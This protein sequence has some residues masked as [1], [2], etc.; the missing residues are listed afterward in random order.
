MGGQLNY[1]GLWL[2]D[3]YG[4]GHSMAKPLSTTYHNP[5]LSKQPEFKYTD[6]EVWKVSNIQEDIEEEEAKKEQRVGVSFV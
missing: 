2:E 5:T 4:L 3:E 1:F 6:L